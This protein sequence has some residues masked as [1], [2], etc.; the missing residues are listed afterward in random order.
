MSEA[1]PTGAKLHP[2]EGFSLVFLET[3]SAAGW[4]QEKI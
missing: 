3:G 2:S 4:N 1:G